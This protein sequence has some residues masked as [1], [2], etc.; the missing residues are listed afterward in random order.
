MTE[1]TSA[2]FI[3]ELTNKVT[4]LDQA[5]VA[6][7]ADVPRGV[8][9]PY[10]FGQS[11]PDWLWRVVEPPDEEWAK[12]V[13]STNALITQLDGDDANVDLARR[14]PVKGT[15]TSS[16]SAPTLMAVMLQALGVRDGDRVLEVGTGTGYNAALLCHRVGAEHVTSIDVDPTLVGAARV[17]LARIGYIPHLVTGD[18]AHGVPDRAPFEKIIA[19]VALPG[20]PR[21]WRE[22]TTPGGT[23]LL[24]LDLTGRGGL[25]AH[26]EVDA[27][28]VAQGRFLTDHGY[29]MQCATTHTRER[30]SAPRT[31]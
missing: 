29:F 11:A 17:R 13:H 23:I 30:R 28:G 6:A 22:Q 3:D 20:L 26:L 19:T 18:G 24:P 5:W 25:L 10:F 12:A 2:T 1:N 7:F 16:S 31:G 4:P 21:A 15:P 9:V 27:A 14:E 8:F